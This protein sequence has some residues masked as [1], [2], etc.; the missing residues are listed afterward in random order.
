MIWRWNEND[1][2]KLRNQREVCSSDVLAITNP[3]WT[4]VGSNSELCSEKL[5]AKPPD[6]WHGSSFTY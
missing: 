6:L 5:V 1:D 3:T 4:T 2:G